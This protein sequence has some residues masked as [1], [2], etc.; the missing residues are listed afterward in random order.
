MG[1][2][3][4]QCDLCVV[5]G[6]GNAYRKKIEKEFKQSSGGR[7]SNHAEIDAL[8]HVK[9]SPNLEF[10]K[11]K[12]SVNEWLCKGCQAA[13]V[14]AA[15][16]KKTMIVVEVTESTEGYVKEHPNAVQNANLPVYIVYADGYAHYFTNMNGDPTP[17]VLKTAIANAQ[18]A[19]KISQQDIDKA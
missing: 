9:K 16:Q 11:L 12:F 7:K 18:W 15:V 17:K 4:I 13:F 14:K 10:D 2:R 1:T 3:E 19:I 6:E 5:N 8:E